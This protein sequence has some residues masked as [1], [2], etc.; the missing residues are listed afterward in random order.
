MCKHAPY[1]LKRLDENGSVAG[2]VDHFYNVYQGDN[3]ALEIEDADGLAPAAT[4]DSPSLAHRYL[5]GAAVD[6]ILTSEDDAGAVCWGLG[7]H[8]GTIRDVV[9]KDVSVR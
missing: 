2:G 4:A 5:Y 6:E 7:D 1:V 8:E 9:D 3:V